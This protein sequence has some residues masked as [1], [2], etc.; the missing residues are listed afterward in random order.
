MEEENKNSISITTDL[1]SITAA[2]EDIFRHSE[3]ER[4]NKNF[5]EIFHKVT[6][7]KGLKI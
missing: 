5:G 6:T 2:I 7:Y 3:S 4:Y 1:V